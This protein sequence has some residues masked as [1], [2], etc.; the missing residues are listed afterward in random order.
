MTEKIIQ[1]GHAQGSTKLLT[2]QIYTILI[3]K[4]QT[5]NILQQ[6]T[7]NVLYTIKSDKTIKMKTEFKDTA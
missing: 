3:C 6:N 5:S 1:K 7:Y 2:T 4:R